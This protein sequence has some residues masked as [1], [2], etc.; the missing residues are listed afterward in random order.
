MRT[1][2]GGPLHGLRIVTL[3]WQAT[4]KL[5]GMV[6]ADNGATVVELMDPAIEVEPNFELAEHVWHRGKDLVPFEGASQLA[7]MIANADIFITDF[8]PSELSKLDADPEVLL[9]KHPSLVVLQVSG[10]GRDSKHVEDEWTEMLAWARL[11]FFYRQPGYR[12]GPKMPTFPAGSYASVFNGSTAALAAIHARNLT[13]KGQ[14]VDTSI[15]DGLAAQQTMLWYW[16]E[17][18]KPSNK[19]LDIRGGGM[20]RLV[21]EAYQCADGEWLHIHTGSKGAFSRLMALAGLQEQIPPI[22]TEAAS[23]LGQPIEKWQLELIHS[24][25]PAMFFTKTRDEWRKVFREQ[26]IAAMPDLL[27]GEVFLDP[28]AIENQLS[29]LVDLPTGETVRAAGAV[30]KFSGTPAVPSGTA[31]RKV[32]AP[33]ALADLKQASVRVAPPKLGHGQLKGQWPLKGLKVIDFGVHFAGPF[34]SRLLADLGA[35]VIKIENLSGCPLRPVSQGRF[36]NAANHH[37]RTIAMNLKK[38]EARP[39]IEKLVRWADI[40]HHNLRPGVAEDLALGYEDLRDINPRIIYCHSPAFG[41]IGPYKELPG[42]EPLSSAITGLMMRH[43]DC[44]DVGPYSAIGSMDP[45]NGMLGAAGLM[46]AIYH[47][48]RTGE[49]QFIEC[50]Q[51]GSA[52]L[53]TPETVVRASGEIHDPMKVDAEQYGF[54]WWKRLYQA[55]DGWLAVDAWHSKAREG[56]LKTSGAS[57]DNAAEGISNWAAE[58]ATTD[59]VAELRSAAVPCEPVGAAYDGDVYFFDEENL[60]LGRAIVFPNVPRWGSYR[61]LGQFWRFSTSPLRQPQEGRLAPGIGDFTREILTEQGLSD[62][63][64]DK[65]IANRVVGVPKAAA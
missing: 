13:G 53:S 46:M 2:K 32:T 19:P 42:F 6:M 60:R 55:K 14:I 7:A 54:S 24:T 51:M 57:E 23:E 52:M 48:D 27:G 29:M 28:Q 31:E 18:D 63:E 37:K 25:L 26:D 16:S 35:D 20:G 50:P 45:G 39:V 22:P 33:E 17:L 64:I 4:A 56:L 38:P 65:L 59:A 30:L 44:R 10:Y 43:G 5:I 11:G 47:R 62:G 8:R 41:S 49:G 61:D 34:A 40:I 58:Q 15:A 36:F 1:R 21:L 9:Q 12:P 3:P